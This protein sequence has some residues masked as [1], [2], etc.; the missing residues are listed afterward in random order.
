MIMVL[1]KML[2]MQA[3]WVGNAGA[4]KVKNRCYW[5][6][7]KLSA[8]SLVQ[9]ISTYTWHTEGSVLSLFSCQNL[10]DRRGKNRFFGQAASDAPTSP[11]AHSKDH[12]RSCTARPGAAE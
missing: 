11:E 8:G 10:P 12:D 4:R 5:S 9:R 7:A 3:N 2:D 6:T 1:L